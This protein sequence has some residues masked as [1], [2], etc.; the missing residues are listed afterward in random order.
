MN[1]CFFNVL[2]PDKYSV[3]TDSFYL[4]FAL[5]KNVRKVCNVGIYQFF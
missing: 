5:F 1:K 2:P 4:D 3:N